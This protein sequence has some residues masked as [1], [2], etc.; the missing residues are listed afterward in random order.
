[1]T[2]FET[3][4]RD[5]ERPS[6]PASSR[7]CSTDYYRPRNIPLRGCQPRD[8]IKQAL[9]L[10]AYL[11]RPAHL[12]PDLLEAACNSYFVDDR[13]ESAVYA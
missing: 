5:L 6:S 8:L 4:C 9:S 7:I 1:M 11:G 12:T 10:A 2:I 3:C 13:D